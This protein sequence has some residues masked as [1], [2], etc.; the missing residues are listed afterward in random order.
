MKLWKRVLAAT[1]MVFSVLLIIVLV[2]GIVGSW[3]VNSSLTDGIVQVSTGIDTALANTDNALSRLDT[4]V[5]SARQRV[6]LF[7]ETVAAAGENLAENPVFLTAIAERLDLGIA[8][9]V[10]EVRG[11]VQTIRETILVAQ[12]TVQTLNALP[13]VSIGGSVAD[14]GKLQTLSEALTSLTDGVREIRDGVRAARAEG[15]TGVVTTL[16]QGTSRLDAGLETIETA[17]SGAEARVSALRTEASE[18]KSKLTFWLD[19][20]SV[21]TTLALLW[22][23]F[24]QVVTFV[25]GLSIYKGENLFARWLGSPAQ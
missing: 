12:N 19:A 7:D 18:F 15:I 16:G 5:S 21:V 20:V 1:V 8:P 9:A 24:A 17:V 23:I 13:F 11:T 25:L 22:L 2:A 3:I 14:D 4:A 10:D 6:D